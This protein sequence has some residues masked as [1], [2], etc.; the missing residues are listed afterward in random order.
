[1]KRISTLNRAQNLFG[2]GKDGFRNGNLLTAVQATEFDADWC[3]AVQEELAAIVEAAGLAV[4]PANN[5]QILEA[6]QRLIDA[7]SGNYALDTGAANAYVVA[8]N[9]AI[10]AYGDGVTVRV[11][12]VAANTGASTLNAGGG[13]KA[14]T[15]HKGTALVAADI[16]AGSVFEAIFIAAD[17]RFVITSLVPSQALSR[18]AAD[19]RYA[20]IIA[21]YRASAVAGCLVMVEI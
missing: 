18:T 6:V 5:A 8:L 10:G 16:P 7:Q 9:P 14:L 19:A 1:M 2:A 3:N 12:A 21:G 17:N 15:D 20:A 11:K 13:V 4:N